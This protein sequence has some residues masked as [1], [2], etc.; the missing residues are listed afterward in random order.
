[1]DVETRATAP[2]LI[3]AQ[4]FGARDWWVSRRTSGRTR[5]SRRVFTLSVGMGGGV[6]YGVHNNNL[7][8]T[9]R[10]VVER[11]FLADRGEGL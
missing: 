3:R 2:V 7:S 4:R 8:N 9:E 5:R 11:V 6:V 10:A 1:V